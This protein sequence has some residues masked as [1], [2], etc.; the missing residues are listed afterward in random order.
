MRLRGRC[1]LCALDPAGQLRD[2]RFACRDERGLAARFRPAVEPPGTRRHAHPRA[3]M[4]VNDPVRALLRHAV[5]TVA[6]RGA[7]ACRDAP[8]GFAAFR[9]AEGSRSAGE[10]LAHIGDLYDW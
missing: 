8:A 9:V 10:I 5:A 2:R 6:Y 1:E 3:G 7:K 4:G